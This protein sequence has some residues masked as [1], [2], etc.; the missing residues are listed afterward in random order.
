[1]QR[2]VLFPWD[3]DFGQSCLFHYFRTFLLLMLPAKAWKMFYWQLLLREFSDFVAVKTCLEN[4]KYVPN[5]H[6]DQCIVYVGVTLQNNK[7]CPEHLLQ[8]KL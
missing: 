4:Y 6:T 5:H 3:D 7:L 1:M 2:V 8:I